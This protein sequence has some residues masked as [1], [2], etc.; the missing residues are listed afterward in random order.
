VSALFN[1]SSG[2]VDKNEQDETLK[3]PKVRPTT[4]RSVD[5]QTK[6]PE[7]V[8][9]ALETELQLAAIAPTKLSAKPQPKAPLSEPSRAEMVSPGG[10]EVSGR[11]PKTLVIKIGIGILSALILVVGIF[12]ILIYGFHSTNPVTKAVAGIIPYPAERV[13]GHFVSYSDYLFEVSAN[14]K[15]Y[16]SNAKL[17]NQTAVGWDSTEGK[18]LLKQIKQHALT[19]LEDDTITAQLAQ[20]YKVTV[21]DKET[22]D[23]INTLYKKYGGQETLLKTLSQIYGWD[24]NDLK[25][26]IHK[27]LLAQKVQTAIASDKAIDAQTKS[28]AIDV[29]TKL[30]AGADFAATA[31]QYSQAADASS[32]GDLGTVAKGQVEDAVYT[33]AAALPVGSLS[34]VIKTQYGYQII[35]VLDK[36]D[37][38]IHISHVLIQA[39]SFTDYFA[40]QEK[41]AKVTTF[42]KVS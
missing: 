24:L 29:L 26:V 35:K 39:I 22:N 19:K 5:A 28:K 40:Q 11:S 34:D 13:N 16:I 33:A 14:Q 6:R 41:S 10:P 32:G 2:V 30:K 31:K 4:K 8:K 21:S 17:N 25:K 12:A 38:G 15:A 18:K 9:P 3:K 37:A 36:S 27:Q 7:G 20:K 23:L 1:G 42:I